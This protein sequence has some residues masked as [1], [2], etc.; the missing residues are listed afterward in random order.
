MKSSVFKWSRSHL[1]E[2]LGRDEAALTWHFLRRETAFHAF[3]FLVLMYL[4]HTTREM[5]GITAGEIDEIHHL[6]VEN[7]RTS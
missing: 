7:C 4:S 1:L 3:H 5:H 6:R 2:I